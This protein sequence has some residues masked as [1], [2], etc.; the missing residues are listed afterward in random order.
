[1]VAKVSWLASPKLTRQLRSR[2]FL[3]KPLCLQSPS[4]SS[5]WGHLKDLKLKLAALA[6]LGPDNYLKR[7]LQFGMS[8]NKAY[9]KVRLAQDSLNPFGPAIRRSSRVANADKN[10]FVL[11]SNSFAQQIARIDYIAATQNQ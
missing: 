1:M 7:D 9:A 11:Q 2:D 4:I 10:Q 5:G 6:R 8:K 3:L